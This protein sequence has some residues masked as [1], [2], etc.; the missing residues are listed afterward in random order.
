MFIFPFTRVSRECQMLLTREREREGEGVVKFTFGNSVWPDWTKFGN[1]LKALDNFVRVYLVF[2]KR[3]EPSLTILYAIVKIFIVVL[4]G[5]ILNNKY[6]HLVTL[7][8][9]LFS[10][11]FRYK[12]KRRR[13]L[14]SNLA[15]WRKTPKTK[16]KA[17]FYWLRLNVIGGATT[18]HRMTRSC[19]TLAIA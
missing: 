18:F 11:Y 10:F 17:K 7:F 5:Q 15:E 2:G 8:G 6:S 14:C 4:S 9:T 3:I 13:R 12:K 16:L 1:L 19:T